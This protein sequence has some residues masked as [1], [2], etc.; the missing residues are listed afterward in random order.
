MRKIWVLDTTLRDGEQSPGVSLTSTE[1]VEIAL[2]LQKLGV[3]RIETGF[4]ATSPGEI[5]SMQEIAKQVTQATL[6]G[7][8]R[9]KEQDIDAVRE[10]LRG[11]E[12]A[13]LHLF[14]ATS[15]IHRHHKLRMDKTKVLE[16]AAAAIRYG[17]KY[18][19][20]VEFSA[21]DASRTELDFICEVVDMAIRAG[22]TVVNLPDTV[23][24]ASP[25]QFGEMFRIVKQQVPGI[26]K[27]NLAHIVMM[28]L[29][30]QQLTRWR[31]SVMV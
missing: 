31:P 15:P 2:Q 23:G 3:D 4:P 11:A 14:L 13:C 25:D 27:Y 20:K 1:K 8:A 22:A 6:V 9:S 30:W 24:Y 7:F 26:E 10:A 16:T 18:F 29:V 19:S 28:I 21:E 12:D 5:T 17:R